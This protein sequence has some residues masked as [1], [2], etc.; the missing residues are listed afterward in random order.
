MSKIANIQTTSF[1]KYSLILFLTY[2][3]NSANCQTHITL[4]PPKALNSSSLTELLMIQIQNNLSSPVSGNIEFRLSQNNSIILSGVTKYIN[5]QPTS[6]LNLT[7]INVEQLVKPYTFS[8]TAPSMQKT[9]LHNNPLPLGNYT[10]CIRFLS[11]GTPFSDE[12]CA[13]TFVTPSTSITNLKLLYPT[14][15][16]LDV[17]L[18]PIFMWS[19]VGVDMRYE[20]KVVEILN[21]QNKFY[22]INNAPHLLQDNL[23]STTLIYPL[24]ARELENCKEYAWQIKTYDKYKQTPS[25][26]TGS[27]TSVNQNFQVSEIYSFKTPCDDNP[28]E[29]EESIKYVLLKKDFTTNIHTF[30]DVVSFKYEANKYSKNFIEIRITKLST[31]EVIYYN[32]EFPLNNSNGSNYLTIDKKELKIP[33]KSS[34]EE[35]YLLEA[36]NLK[37][38]ILLTKFKFSND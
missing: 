6:M 8:Y 30:K 15:N 7:P 16:S 22:A 1:V 36:I 3:I 38:Q 27:P 10:V 31:N 34:K 28:E 14:D 26:E 5:L 11:N 37:N 32:K 4:T 9:I 18:N 12:V 13:S 24:I 23:T 33:K 2:F 19:N 21:G 35:I 25:G 20:L 29:K 17:S